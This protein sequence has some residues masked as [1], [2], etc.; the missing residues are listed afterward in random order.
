M[1]RRVF[2]KICGITS[3]ADGLLA[4]AAGADAVGF[5]FWPRS[6]RAVGLE[7]AQRIARALPAPMLRVGVFVDADPADVARAA[8]AVGLDMLQL[9]GDES[10]DACRAAPRRV[11][12]A[13]RVGAGF[14]PGA[15]LRYRD[16][17]TAV[18]LDARHEGGLPGGTGRRFDWSLARA[19]RADL[20]FLGLAGG[21]DAANVG[22]AIREVDPDLV[23][24]SSGVEAAPGRKDPAKVRAFVEA[25]RSAAR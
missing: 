6:P 5:V 9:H 23:D 8:D 14:E 22:A 2:L 12:K 11:M 15:A 1:A 19:L 18:L 17:A 21:L 13:V 10:V 7:Q 16:A 4:A 3:E 24:V 25:V 20:P